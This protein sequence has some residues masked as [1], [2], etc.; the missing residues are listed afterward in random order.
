MAAVQL[1][2]SIK[3]E[4]TD[5]APGTT[6]PDQ[7]HSIF[8]EPVN[9]VDLEERILQ[10]CS[11]HP[12]GITDDVITQDQPLVDADRR[13]K[14]LQRLLSQVSEQLKIRSVCFNSMI[15]L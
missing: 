13:C 11:E 8:P 7:S 15:K 9:L 5:E 10:L 6:P 1:T 14:A 12:K 3:Q 4:P 2:A